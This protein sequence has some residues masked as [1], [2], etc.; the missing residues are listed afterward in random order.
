VPAADRPLLRPW[1]NAIV[2]MYEYGRT[3]QIEDDAERAADE[4]VEYLRALAA[5]RRQAPGED[6]LTHLVTVRDAAGD[7][8][9]E[10]ELVTTCILLLN[11]GHE[12]T[13]NVSGNGLLALLE[14][15][16]EL[17]RLRADPGLLPT[18]I[19]ELMRFDSPL[20]LFERTATEDVEVGG[21]TVARGQKIAALLGSANRDPAV[22]ADPDTLDVG[23]ADN[24]HI[25]FGAGVHF[26]IGAPLARVELQASFGALLSRTSALVLGAPARRRPEFVMRGLYD[27]PVVL[28]R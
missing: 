15:P 8:L 3:T 18:A 23:R 24:P 25:S 9:T 27:L 7:R 11:A 2:K 6:L 22:F 21:A 19:E 26:C 12:A 20:Q 5:E 1:S 13:V 17:A 14:H 16:A 10:D 4:F 28:T